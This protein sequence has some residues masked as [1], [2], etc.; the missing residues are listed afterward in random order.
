MIRLAK[1]LLRLGA[2]GIL[3]ILLSLSAVL[4]WLTGTQQ[5]LHF[6]L[7]K[8]APYGVTVQQATGRLLWGVDLQG[9][10]LDLGNTTVATG[11]L[12]LRWRPWQFPVLGTLAIDS[13]VTEDLTIETMPTPPS[14]PKPLPRVLLPLPI[15]IHHLEANRFSYREA[16]QELYGAQ[17][18][19]L[20]AQATGSTVTIRRLALTQPDHRA[21]LAG[22]IHLQDAYPMRINL[23][24]GLDHIPGA[25]PHTPPLVLQGSVHGDLERL[26]V[27][28]QA[29]SPQ[30]VHIEA[31]VTQLLRTLHADARVRLAPFDVA[32]LFDG[33]PQGLYGGA[34]H[35]QGN[36]DNLQLN[37][38]LAAS[39][40]PLGSGAM[41]ISARK[42]GDTLHDLQA[43]WRS[44][45]GTVH[46]QGT[47]SS[48]E[49]QQASATLAWKNL[50]LPDVPDWRLDNG[51]LH[52]KGSAAGFDVQGTSQATWVRA[53]QE[54]EVLQGSFDTHVAPQAIQVKQMVLHGLGATLTLQGHM[55]LQSSMQFAVKG[56]LHDV[57]PGRFAAQWPGRLETAWEASGHIAPRWQVTAS[58]SDLRGQLRDRPV[59]GHLQASVAPGDYRLTALE[60]HSGK[61]LLQA[62]GLLQRELSLALRLKAPQLD[63]L[64]PQA[65][66]SLNLAADLSGPLTWPDLRLEVTGRKLRY[67]D[68]SLEELQGSGQLFSPQDGG[69]GTLRLQARQ[70][71]SG[72]TQIA[73][74]RWKLD[75]TASQHSVDL[76]AEGPTYDLQ[77]IHLAMQGGFS[78]K[79][80]Q[81]MLRELE[82]R[83]AT[84]GRFAL[85][86]PAALSWSQD[87]LATLQTLCLQQA[88]MRLCAEGALR[89]P[90][91]ATVAVSV[92]QVRLHQFEP[93]LPP[94]YHVAGDLQGQVA[95]QQTKGHWQGQG[96]IAL[97]HNMLTMEDDSAEGVPPIV[98][99][100]MPSGRLEAELARDWQLNGRLHLANQG[101][102]Q[103]QGRMPDP[104]NQEFDTLPMQG[105]VRLQRL[106]LGFLGAAVP[107]MAAV[108]MEANGRLDITGTVK[109]PILAGG[110]AIANGRFELPALGLEVHDLDLGMHTTQDNQIKLAGALTSGKGRLKIAA[111]GGLSKGRLHAQG[112]IQGDDV[113]LANIPQ[114][115]V[116]GSPN[117]ALTM[118]PQH[119]HVAGTLALPKGKLQPALLP[120]S[121]S[122]SSDEVIV[123]Q[124]PNQDTAVQQASL[125]LSARLR[126]MAGPDLAVRAMG[127][128]G[129]LEGDLT[130]VIEPRN[131]PVGIGEM[132]L[133]EG[134]YK[135]YGQDL[136]I[137]TGRVLFTGGPL[138]NPGL[139]LQATRAIEG[140]TVGLHVRGTVNKPAMSFTSDPPQSES[141]T[142]A[143]LLFGR[144]MRQ[145]SAEESNMVNQGMLN[146]GV[147]GG[148]FLAKMVGKRF[149]LSDVHVESTAGAPES[150][151]LVVGRQLSPRI[152]VGYGVGIFDGLSTAHITYSLTP[153]LSLRTQA[154]MESAADLLYSL[155]R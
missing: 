10:Q 21:T 98:L 112:T 152:T 122:V 48:L 109:E 19:W 149:G 56:T 100:D 77:R 27:Q 14:P 50:R 117:L 45:T 128:Q 69:K 33:A 70:L 144:P 119:L 90:G 29:S 143:Y 26:H 1:R 4:L 133:V 13:L 22:V 74:L 54:P 102:M 36:P 115:R 67:Q 95:L 7:H 6:L 32:S 111:L 75:G 125:P 76:V 52:L 72:A 147:R 80:W 30:Q 51:T 63:D 123:G 11:H 108:N 81:G 139:D 89:G 140:G 46:V 84:L 61:A 146:A 17:R 94:G 20:A 124:Q 104:A 78:E 130:V 118:T 40:S 23:Q 5:G 57:D 42:K 92:H 88:P 18:I 49:T 138:S 106:P 148:E 93:L 113:L 79:R 103:L 47:V 64:L 53:H 105:M 101:I 37:A 65:A 155:E 16:G 59:R 134:S 150:A 129:K 43:D 110:F 141:D 82:I 86:Q 137:G 85:A 15:T 135:A 83:H 153:S 131:P 25:R 68:W 96:H 116:T 8:A 58:L 71:R 39:H 60:L 126:L 55:S 2:L 136:Q 41:L 44:P 66:G 127:V 38:Q 12:R 24:A 87:G 28:L 34:I 145:T 97:A 62:H 99:L 3:A 151:Q 142:L 31:Q 121:V 35:I 91:A 154:G 132:R 73:M 114:A 9:M 107:D 120:S